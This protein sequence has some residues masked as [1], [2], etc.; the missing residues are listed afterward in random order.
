MKGFAHEGEFEAG[1]TTHQQA[2][3]L[4]ALTQTPVDPNDAN[5]ITGA[6]QHLEKMYGSQFNA[7]STHLAASLKAASMDGSIGVAGLLKINDNG[8]GYRLT[9]PNDAKDKEYIESEREYALSKSR[10]EIKSINFAVD[11]EVAGGKVQMAVNSD[12]AVKNLAKLMPSNRLGMTRMSSWIVRKIESALSNTLDTKPGN[13]QQFVD[14]MR[15][16]HTDD[17]ATRELFSRMSDETKKKLEGLGLMVESRA[18][19]DGVPGNRVSVF[20]PSSEYDNTDVGTV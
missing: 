7:F 4:S 19:K 6:I 15:K 14:A 1:N 17:Q 10:G 8:E 3:V 13:I 9:D 12:A 16:L 20:R 2:L 5:S 18:G 11:Q